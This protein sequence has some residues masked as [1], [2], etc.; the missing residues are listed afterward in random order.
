MSSCSISLGKKI[1]LK[2][3]MKNKL[4][5][6]NNSNFTSE[7]LFNVEEEINTDEDTNMEYM[8]E[9]KPEWYQAHVLYGHVSKN[10]LKQI[11]CSV[12]GNINDDCEETLS[13]P[14]VMLRRLFIVL[15]N[16]FMLI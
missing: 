4:F 12:D 10:Q 11:G 2:F 14:V 15:E 1:I 3:E 13:K 8:D 7:H 9:D 5:P 6:V 16:Y